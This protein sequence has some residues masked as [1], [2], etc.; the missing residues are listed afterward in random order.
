MSNVSV[1]PLGNKYRDELIAKIIDIC[2]QNDYQLISNFEWYISVLVDLSR[3]QGGSEHGSLIAQQMM[4]VAIRVETIRPFAAEQMA[5]LL[6]NCSLFA[7]NSSVCE[8]LFAAAWIC[9]EFS[10]HLHNRKVVMFALLPRVRFL[11]HIEASFLLN[12]AKIFVE[13]GH[14]LSQ[15]DLRSISDRLAP[16]VSS[17]DL[18]VHERANNFLNLLEHQ[19]LFHSGLFKS[20]PLNPVAAKAQ[21]KVPL[22]Q[23]L[24]LDTPFV[25][26]EDD[27]IQVEDS[28]GF[29]SDHDDQNGDK[30]S[31]KKRKGKKGKDEKKSKKGKRD[32]KNIE[33]PMTGDIITEVTEEAVHDKKEKKKKTPKVPKDMT[34]SIP[35]LSSSDRFVDQL[36]K[37]KKSKKKTDIEEEEEPPMPEHA[38]TIK[39]LEMPEG[40]DEEDVNSDEDTLQDPHRALA[41]VVLDPVSFQKPPSPTK[42]VVEKKKKKTKKSNGDIV[43]KPEKKRSKKKKEVEVKTPVRDE[44]EETLEGVDTQATKSG[45]HSLINNDDLTVLFSSLSLNQEDNSLHCSLRI[46]GKQTEKLPQF[47][48]SWQDDDRV[49]QTEQ[50]MDVD[51]PSSL[52]LPLKIQ[53]PSLEA[54]SVSGTMKYSLNDQE[55]IVDIVIPIPLSTFVRKP[56]T[57]Q[58]L[59]EVVSGLSVLSSLTI[60][61]DGGLNKFLQKL[62]QAIP[63]KGKITRTWN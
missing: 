60:D 24:D 61:F 22:P 14:E 35:G 43:E 23:G 11:S 36:K 58:P 63:L 46:E 27:N 53:S 28:L 42:V 25:V 4:D 48:I 32:K 29:T 6:D 47:E 33:E 55:R 18:E 54:S 56:E 21:K 49:K 38:V 50:T 26:I 15:E 10:N 8:V 39:G 13:I 51:I 59:S 40:A 34:S 30:K 20:Y 9:G 31:K 7:N 57:D 16:Y 41:K 37:S 17:E 12:A 19:S 1:N 44:Y 52:L 3:V 62:T 5:V 2:S 45:F